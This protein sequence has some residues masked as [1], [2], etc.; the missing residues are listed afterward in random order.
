[1]YVSLQLSHL[2]Q[3][4]TI[5]QFLT[6]EAAHDI[7]RQKGKEDVGIIMICQEDISNIKTELKENIGRKVIIKGAMGR[8]KYFEE[9]VIIEKTYSNIFIV[10]NEKKDANASYRYTDILTNDLKISIFD[11]K[12]Y[13]PLIPV[14]LKQKF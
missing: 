10:K 9:E 4:D 2:A 13:A 12:D 14:T 5:K 3:I 11:G 8:K 7:I 6:S 1:M